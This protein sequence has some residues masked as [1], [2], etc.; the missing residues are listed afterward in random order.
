[1]FFEGFTLMVNVTMS[2]SLMPGT[3]FTSDIRVSVED[4]TR[5]I[6]FKDAEYVG[7]VTC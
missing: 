6:V 7:S 4:R 1:M 2:W 3:T 5:S